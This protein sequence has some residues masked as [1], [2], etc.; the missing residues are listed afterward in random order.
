M[1]TFKSPSLGPDGRLR[2]KHL[3]AGLADASL[4][5]TFVPKWKATTAYLAGDKVLSPN[6]DVVKAIANFTSGASYNAANWNRT[7]TK[8]LGLTAVALGDSQTANGGTGNTNDRGWWVWMNALL[9]QPWASFRN[10]GVNGD[11]LAQM[12]ARI[13]TDVTPYNPDIVFVFG[14]K[15]SISQGLTFAQVQNDY[16]AILDALSTAGITRVVVV[17]D[18]PH[19]GRPAGERAIRDQMND[20]LRRLP[21]LRHQVIA[22]IDAY[23]TV[24]NPATGDFNTGMAYDALH[25]SSAGAQAMGALAAQVMKPLLPA[26]SVLPTGPDTLNLLGTKGAFVGSTA[27]LATGWSEYHAGTASTFSKVTRTDGIQGEWQ[28]IATVAGQHTQQIYT[29]MTTGFAV[30]DTLCAISEC[31][32]DALGESVAAGFPNW[33]MQ[34]RFLDGA[35]A[36]LA[37]PVYPVLAMAS[38]D[39]RAKAPSGT[40]VMRTPNFVVPTGTV[41]LRIA[42][43]DYA[44][45][46]T[47]RHGRTT[48]RKV[49]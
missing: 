30:G 22:T 31:Q 39:G 44:A 27:G 6:G 45:A 20:W 24:V 37:A 18:P 12:L 17:T 8:P 13:P 11:T 23:A 1:A 47:I 14:G 40:F 19:D 10:A 25:P 29:D 32:V 41:K 35:S 5:A 26:V 7:T 46:T 21:Q 36:D 43:L 48:V 33:Q 38:S 28:Q 2:E 49:V 16:T 4:N 3:P 34:I 9:G 42:F 15:N